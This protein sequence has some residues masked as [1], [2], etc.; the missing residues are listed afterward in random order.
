[1][2]AVFYRP[3]DLK[4]QLSTPLTAT[5]PPATVLKPSKLAAAEAKRIDTLTRDNVFN[6]T[7]QQPLDGSLY[8]NLAR[9]SAG[10]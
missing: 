8:L 9:G 6:A 4:R 5:L 2:Q 3:G 7:F 10:G 1:V